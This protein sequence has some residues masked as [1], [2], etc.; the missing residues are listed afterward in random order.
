MQATDALTYLLGHL[1]LTAMHTDPEGRAEYHFAT[2]FPLVLTPLDATTLALFAPFDL[3]EGLRREVLL[4][5][6]LEANLQGAE[7]GAAAV[8]LDAHGRPGLRDVM[9]L[10]GMSLAALQL[11]FV[12]FCLYFEF[13]RGTRLPALV[14]ECA[15]DDPPPG[16]FLRL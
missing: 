13:W 5:R 11:R 8:C 16:G 9:P 12:D 7:T 4:P 1:D 2:P 10:D 15:P 3:P 14:A 6:L